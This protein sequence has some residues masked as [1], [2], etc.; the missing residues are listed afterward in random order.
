MVWSSSKH[1]SPFL[2]ALIASQ[3]TKRTPRSIRIHNNT[4]YSITK[5]VIIIVH[6]SIL[7]SFPFLPSLSKFYVILLN[8]INKILRN[9]FSILYTSTNT[10]FKYFVLLFFQQSCFF[11]FSP[12]GFPLSSSLCFPSFLQS[13]YVFVSSVLR[14]LPFSRFATVFSLFRLSLSLLYRFYRQSFSNLS[15]MSSILLSMLHFSS[16]LFSPSISIA[17]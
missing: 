5:G 9:F 15:K 3:S 17:R 13:P 14:I 11:S 12:V 10:S 8:Y 7:H 2:P 4:I 6:I 1:F 16:C